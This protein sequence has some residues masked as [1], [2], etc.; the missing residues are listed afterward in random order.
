MKYQSVMNGL[1]PENSAETVVGSVRETLYCCMA[2]WT[3]HL[4]YKRLDD[5]QGKAFELGQSTV[6]GL[7]GVLRCWMRQSGKVELF[8]GSQ[9]ASN[10]LHVKFNMDT[11]MEVYS[12]DDYNHLQIDVVSLFL[13]FLVQ[14]I[15][16]GLEVIDTPADVAFVQNLVY[17]VERTYRT[18]DFGIWGIGSA[19]N[20]GTCEIN[21]R[22]LV[23]C[24]LLLGQI[25][26]PRSCLGPSLSL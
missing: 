4:A 14:A 12:D 5:N 10:S 19:C 25:K 7:Q 2:T 22:C 13:L 26:E 8:K 9:K 3:L 21:A 1:Y 16:S 20:N 17:Y 11:S 15:S 24:S 6:M 18:P 23:T